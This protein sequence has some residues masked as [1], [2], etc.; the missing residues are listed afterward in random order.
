MP[1][2]AITVDANSSYIALAIGPEVH[3]ANML[4]HNRTYT[5]R[6]QQQVL[7]FLGHFATISILP[8]PKELPGL[9]ID[10]VYHGVR[11]RGLHFVQRGSRLIVSY[12]NHGIVYVLI[13]L[14]KTF[15]N[16][17]TG[18]GTYNP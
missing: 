12:L 9:S 18:A 2:Y 15:M 3:L 10:D 1:V 17:I 11:G 16:L 4:K 13:Q 14:Q 7:F 8:K 5:D 6:H